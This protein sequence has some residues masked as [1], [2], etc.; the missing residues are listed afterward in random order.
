[1]VNTNSSN[2]SLF[3]QNEVRNTENVVAAKDS[4]SSV[5][6][7]WAGHK[8]NNGNKF[9]FY[10]KLSMF[11]VL[12]L[13][14]QCFNENA[15]GNTFECETRMQ[16]GAFDLGVSRNLGETSKKASTSKQAVK[17]GS[18]SNDEEAEDEDDDK[19]KYRKMA[20]EAYKQKV[21]ERY[22][23]MSDDKPTRVPGPRHNHQ[24]PP[25]LSEQELIQLLRML[26]PPPQAMQK[27]PRNVPGP[28]GD[29]RMPFDSPEQMLQFLKFM[30]DRQNMM[31]G[32]NNACCNFGECE[33]EEE[34]DKSI[35]KNIIRDVSNVA[36]LI[37][38]A[39]P[40]LLM[41]FIGTQRTYLLLYTLSLVKDAY[42][43]LQRVKN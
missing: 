29:R 30:N 17:A 18:S 24:G 28:S 39:L 36:P 34:E 12:F 25:K 1:M 22:K 20:E 15:F 21:E 19:D 14:L 3:A 10:L 9:P 7:T 16:E 42:N 43:F 13:V 4:S 27:R 41:M 26:P 31:A 2:I 38:P 35:I 32:N 23:I 8:T 40:P 33:E 6:G 11:G 37:L 5:K